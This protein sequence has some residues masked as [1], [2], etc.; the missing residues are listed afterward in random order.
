[1][2]GKLLND[3]SSYDASARG[4]NSHPLI[5]RLDMAQLQEGDFLHGRNSL[6]KIKSSTTPKNQSMSDQNSKSNF[7]LLDGK[8]INGDAGPTESFAKTC[9]NSVK[10][11]IVSVPQAC[12]FDSRKS[13]LG[14]SCM[15][16]AAILPSLV[17]HVVLKIH[18]SNANQSS[19]DQD[20]SVT[21]DETYVTNSSLTQVSLSF[22]ILVASAIF[23]QC[24]SKL[25]SRQLPPI[26]NMVGLTGLLPIQGARM[27]S[28]PLWTG[29]MLIFATMTSL[30]LFFLARKTPNR[31]IISVILTLYVILLAM[32][33]FDRM[34]SSSFFSEINF[35]QPTSVLV[36]ESLSLYYGLHQ[37]IQLI[38]AFMILV[39]ASRNM[40]KSKF[41][42][43]EIIKMNLDRIYECMGMENQPYIVSKVIENIKLNA[44]GKPEKISPDQEDEIG[45]EV[46]Y[47]SKGFERLILRQLGCSL[48]DLI[49]RQ[50][51]KC[52]VYDEEFESSDDNS[53]FTRPKSISVA[54]KYLDGWVGKNALILNLK[55]LIDQV[56]QPGSSDKSVFEI[57]C[58]QQVKIEK[59]A[60][61][62]AREK[63]NN[64]KILIHR[65]NDPSQE[66]IIEEEKKQNSHS[67]QQLIQDLS[68]SNLLVEQQA[69]NASSYHKLSEQIEKRYVK[70]RISKTHKNGQ[71]YKIIS[72][73][74]VLE[75]KKVE[76]KS[77]V[78]NRLTS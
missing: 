69:D 45:Y 56:S 74:Q 52:N 53:N 78:S 26:L 68:N 55:Q 49:F 73:K 24:K 50:V 32:K 23:I 63:E 60:L 40:E 3:Y 43:N 66:G 1:M 71:S 34:K 30:N 33:R 41:Q 13:R 14:L 10:Q 65:L 77:A 44:D 9:L 22:C 37:A 38:L 70:I 54:D 6:D 67:E 59:Q 58:K 76:I 75:P 27:P 28:Y 51:E 15:F 42:C 31:V 72:C 2:S 25:L 18:L 35:D 29:S 46:S 7:E 21:K 64:K 11:A 12:T 39:F 36:C 16:V 17:F 47:I 62:L 8:V 19:P 61:M 48:D 5:P 57:K 4:K 20:Y